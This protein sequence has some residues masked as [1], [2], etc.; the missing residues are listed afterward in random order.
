MQ[1]CMKLKE[2]SGEDFMPLFTYNNRFNNI[3]IWIKNL[4]LY[5]NLDL[6][7]GLERTFQTNNKS[8]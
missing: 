5:I 3:C 7:F 2:I 8:T 6:D 4:H 1:T